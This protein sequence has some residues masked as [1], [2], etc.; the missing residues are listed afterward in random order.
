[1]IKS[2]TQYVVVCDNTFCDSVVKSVVDFHSYDRQQQ[3]E[4]KI[5]K[6]GW[7]FKMEKDQTDLPKIVCPNCVLFTSELEKKHPILS[8]IKKS[9]FTAF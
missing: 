3:F 4:R 8:P 2:V 6:L 5:K 7:K 1:M 9:S